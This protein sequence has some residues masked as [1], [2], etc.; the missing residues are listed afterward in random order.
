MSKTQKLTRSRNKPIAEVAQG[1][2]GWHW[3]V[4][5]GNGQPVC[6]SAVAYANEKQAINAVRTARAA[7]A[8]VEIVVKASA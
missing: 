3:Q 7:F 2:D 1:E 6:R 4:W 5:A 8:G